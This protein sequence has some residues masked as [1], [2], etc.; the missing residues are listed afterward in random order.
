MWAR[1]KMQAFK[2]MDPPEWG[3]REQGYSQGRSDGGV[4]HFEVKIGLM[5]SVD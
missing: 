4:K 1:I 2:F 5:I 3:G